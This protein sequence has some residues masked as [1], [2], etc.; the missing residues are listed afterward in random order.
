M[1]AVPA[2]RPADAPVQQGCG[3]LPH[4]ALGARALSAVRAAQA[5]MLSVP[6]ED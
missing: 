5:G 4:T 1:L 6:I 2:T 3:G